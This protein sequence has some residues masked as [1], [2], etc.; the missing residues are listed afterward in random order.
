MITV[1][2]YCAGGS[3]NADRNALL[4]NLADMLPHSGYA[5]TVYPRGLLVLYRGSGDY[6]TAYADPADPAI[7]VGRCAIEAHYYL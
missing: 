7:Q 5:L 4:D 1:L 6:L 2:C 3:A